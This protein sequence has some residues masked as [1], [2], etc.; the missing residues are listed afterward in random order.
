MPSEPGRGMS[1]REAAL[2]TDIPFNTL[3]RVEKGHTPDLPKFKRLVEWCGTDIQQFFEIHERATATT[4]VIAEQLRADRNL[5]PEAAERI[6]GIVD[7]LYKALARPPG[8]RCSPP[9]SGQ[10]NI[11]AGSGQRPGNSAQRLEQSTGSS[12]RTPRLHANP[13]THRAS[14]KCRKLPGGPLLWA[15]SAAAPGLAELPEHKNR[16]E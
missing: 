14:K 4:E 8:D 10:D 6:A 15:L 13:M 12:M 3:A 5:P 7:D 11:S 16:R 2:A 9:S 1:L